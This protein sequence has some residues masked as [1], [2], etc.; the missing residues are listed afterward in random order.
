MFWQAG[1]G[2]KPENRNKSELPLKINSKP[3]FLADVMIAE[4]F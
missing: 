3:A 4:D 1:H 2:V